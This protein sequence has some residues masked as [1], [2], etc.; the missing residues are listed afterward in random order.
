MLKMR[1]GLTTT[2]SGVFKNLNLTSLM[3]ISESSAQEPAILKSNEILKVTPCT[4]SSNGTA[5]KAAAHY[6]AVTKTNIGLT[7]C[8]VETF[9]D[10]NA[11]SDQGN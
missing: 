8:D 3:F 9:I 5:L 7:V 11:S 4:C 1:P 10:Q 2:K 6:D